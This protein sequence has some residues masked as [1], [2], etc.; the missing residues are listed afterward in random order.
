M[1]ERYTNFQTPLGVAILFVYMYPSPKSAASCVCLCIPRS[2]SATEVQ[3]AEQVLNWVIIRNVF[4][5]VS[6]I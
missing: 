4:M 6:V 1:R 2:R 3:Y 5:E